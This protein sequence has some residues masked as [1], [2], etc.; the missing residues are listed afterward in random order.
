MVIYGNLTKL[1]RDFIGFHGILWDFI[2]WGISWGIMGNI[3]AY[4]MGYIYTHPLVM[5]NSLLLKMVH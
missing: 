2:S 4:R 1:M 3:L 5:T